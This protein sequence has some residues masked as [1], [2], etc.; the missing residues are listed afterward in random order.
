MKKT[1]AKCGVEKHLYSKYKFGDHI[2]SKT[3]SDITTDLLELASNCVMA[4]GQ[5]LIFDSTL[6]RWTTPID[7]K[8]H[9]I[10]NWLSSPLSSGRLITPELIETF[11]KGTMKVPV[12]VIK[13]T[14][15]KK[16]TSTAT[17]TY[18]EETVGSIQQLTGKIFIPYGPDVVTYEHGHYLNSEVM[19]MIDES[20]D[21]NDMVKKFLRHIYRALCSG[22]ELDA[23]VNKEAEILWKQVVD[24]KM[25][26]KEFNFLIHWL[27]AIYR[28]PGVNLQTNVWLVGSLEGV[29][30]GTLVQV[31][32]RVLGFNVV[33][34]LS[35]ED[36][37]RDWN[38]HLQGKILIECDEFD[39]N[40]GHKGPMGWSRWIKATTTAEK[41]LITTRGQT[42]YMNLNVGNYIFTTNN[43]APLKIDQSDRRN[44]FIKTTDDK[45]WVRA[46]IEIQ[47]TMITTNIDKLASGFAYMLGLVRYNKDMLNISFINEAK[48][49]VSTAHLDGVEDWVRNAVIP[50]RGTWASAKA[51]H[52]EYTNWCKSPAAGTKAKVDVLSETSWGR[53]MTELRKS[54]LVDKRKNR[55]G[56][57][58]NI[59]ADFEETYVTEADDHITTITPV[60]DSHSQLLRARQSLNGTKEEFDDD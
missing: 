46:A 1:E 50:Q 29:G 58:Y 42:P 35:Q 32:R 6:N 14:P 17:T 37:G 45:E 25:T 12:T 34:K 30:K 55:I 49:E 38:D 39:P 53:R 36:I 4:N 24:D 16:I 8:K 20:K 56:N 28:R 40:V 5:V 33:G 54:K 10:N 22:E 31:M 60:N 59:V 43:E 23:D 11:F 26:N 15:G 27:S 47:K 57:Q 2:W 48:V 51:L 21:H 52:E 3:K 41:F 44:Q 9:M 7:A 13:E 18:I 19:D